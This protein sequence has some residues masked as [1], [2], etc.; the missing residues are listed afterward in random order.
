MARKH[1]M[2]ITKFIRTFKPHMHVHT[3][4]NIVV[5]ALYEGA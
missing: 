3:Y 2:Y 4:Q 1:H 5:Y